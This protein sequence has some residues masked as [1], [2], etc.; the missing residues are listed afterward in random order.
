MIVLG[1]ECTGLY[2]RW[3]FQ[4]EGGIGILLLA[5]IHPGELGLGASCL[6][7][8]RAGRD[9]RQCA[10]GGQ[11]G[12]APGVI[13]ERG[14]VAPECTWGLLWPVLLSVKEGEHCNVPQK[15]LD[16]IAQRSCHEKYSELL[17]T[18]CEFS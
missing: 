18:E 8:H 11:A 1:G 14:V 5:S 9:S 6:V 13:Q 2:S 10:L 15:F 12:R 3:A 16:E 7:W 4:R 17:R